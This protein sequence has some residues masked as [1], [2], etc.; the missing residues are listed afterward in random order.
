MLIEILYNNI[1]QND[2]VLTSERVVA[3]ENHPSHVSVTTTTGKTY[4]GSFVVGGDG[5]HST[6]RQQ[7]WKEARESDPTWFETSEADGNV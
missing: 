4:T 6:I 2:K 1:Q 5:I 7:M 3:V